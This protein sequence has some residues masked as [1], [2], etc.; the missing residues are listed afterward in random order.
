[1]EG[2]VAGN[3]PREALGSKIHETA[4]L[5]AS[6]LELSK[7]AIWYSLV[8]WP[9]VPSDEARLSIPYPNLRLKTQCC[10]IR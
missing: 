10:G 5:G 3:V 9:T 4:M 2:R 6:H 7:E 1:M 8:G